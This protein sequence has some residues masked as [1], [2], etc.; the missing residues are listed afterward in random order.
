M[1]GTT[2]NPSWSDSVK[3]ENPAGDKGFGGGVS[4]GSSFEPP[5]GFPSAGDSDFWKNQPTDP[6]YYNK[7]KI[8]LDAF[9]NFKFGSDQNK[10]QEQAQRG[11]FQTEGNKNNSSGGFAAQIFPNLSVVQQQSP[12]QPFTY[13]PPQG[14][15]SGIGSAIGTIAGIGASFIPGIGPGIAKA[16]PALGG[17]IGGTAGS[18]FG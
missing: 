13:T 12:Y 3:W 7:G 4:S 9:K 16:L 2:F 18:F 11:G 6:N 10:Y 14:G 15:G 8:F 17:A 1:A 5:S